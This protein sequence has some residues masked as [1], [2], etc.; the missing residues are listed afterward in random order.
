MEIKSIQFGPWLLLL[1]FG[2]FFINTNKLVKHKKI[3]K[4]KKKIRKME[5]N[6]DVMK[7]QTL[8]K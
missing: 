3:N 5:T 8:Q 6:I 2:H 7:T 1:T 4:I